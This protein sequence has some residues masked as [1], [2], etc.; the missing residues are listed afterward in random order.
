ME[1]YTNGNKGKGNTQRSED[2]FLSDLNGLGWRFLWHFL[3]KLSRL[4]YTGASDVYNRD[5]NINTF[6]ILCCCFFYI[7]YDIN[8]GCTREFDEK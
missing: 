7:S 5:R 1:V 3:G 8:F 6:S 4:F 2:N